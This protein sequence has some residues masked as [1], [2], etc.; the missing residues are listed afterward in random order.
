MYQ[1]NEFDQKLVEERVAQFRRQTERYLKGE[2]S[3]DQFRPLRLRNG[4][5]I[6]THAPMLRI[7]G[8][9]GLLNSKQFRKLA[10][11]A[12]TYDKNYCHFTTRQNI[13]FNWPKLE[14]VPDILAELASVQMHAIQTSGNCMRNTTSDHLAGVCL[15]EIED[16]RPYCEIIR[17]WTTLHPEFDYLPRKFKI[18][19]S[20]AT[21]DRAATQLHDI[22]LHLVKNEVG[23]TGFRVYVGGGLGRTPMIGHVIRPFLE[24]QH[25]LSYLEAILRIYNLYGRRDNKYKARIKIL[26]KETGI[27]EFTRQVEAEWL[28][29]KES[30]LLSDQ[31]I[32]DIKQFF[33]PPSYSQDAEKDSTLSVHL[34]Q[35]NDFATWCKLNTLSHKVAGYRVVFL[36][37]KAPDTPPGDMTDAQLDAVADLAD[38][39]T[40]GQIRVTHR[41]NLVFADVKQGDLFPLWQALKQLKL[42]TPNIGTVTD[43]ICCPGLD[44]C[45]L[46]NAGSIGVTRS[47]NEALDNMDYIHDIGD[48]KINIS[49]CMN[50]CAHQS[51][52]HIGILGV[53]KKGAEWYQLTLG[54]SSENEAAIGERLGPSIPKDKVA[55]SITDIL[56]VY[57]KHR[58][59]DEPF[60]NTVKRIGLE[61]FKDKVYADH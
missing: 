42:A 31:R 17:Q 23:E 60:L 22:G 13:Q 46:A 18:A 29:I 48:V 11:I 14:Q 1:Y 30:L 10:H 50:G 54:G 45:S 44:F 51:V 34:Q 32:N 37:L 47:I 59:D 5:Y 6:Q 49:G 12:R 16:P 41:Q 7:A 9:Y 53:D 15:D 25:L 61:P 28:L 57:V 2:L 19:V 35:D 20:G 56:D 52:G 58:L 55:E 39:Y 8:P 26:V 27:E 21:H 3:E 40:F 36:S 38:R 43:I 4:L 24:K 33:V